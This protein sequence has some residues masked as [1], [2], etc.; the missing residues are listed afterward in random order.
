MAITTY[1][2][3]VAGFASGQSMLISKASLSN[4]AAGQYHSLF[5]ATGVP[6]QPAVPT[7]TVA[8]CI[9]AVTDT[10]GCINWGMTVA[11][12]HTAYI[13]SLQISGSVV[14]GFFIADRLLHSGGY[15]SNATTLTAI[16][17]ADLPNDRGLDLT[18]YSDIH[19][20]M[21]TYTDL[22]ATGS[23]Y[24]FTYDSPTSS[25]QTSVVAVPNTCR[26]SRLLEIIP[27]VGHPIVRL[28]SFRVTTASGTAGSWGITAVK[29]HGFYP[30]G[31]A[32]VGAMYDFAQTGLHD[33]PST[34]CLF[35]YI[36]AS[37]TTT[38]VVAGMIRVI[39]G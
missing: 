23:N 6:T 3:L 24:T 14:C 35:P 38:G 1:D 16:T 8:T 37:A 12:G 5:R 20:F 34:A 11:T 17:A 21:E 15:T 4:V 10:A 26:A 18:N 22:G 29:D 9:T 19:W 2:G 33:I 32:N 27:N 13:G 36:I 28:K 31:T 25:V 30:S 7:A 39:K